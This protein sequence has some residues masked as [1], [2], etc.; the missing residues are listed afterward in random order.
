MPA[1]DWS[2]FSLPDPPQTNDPAMYW[3]YDVM[4]VLHRKVD[5]LVKGGCDEYGG[6]CARVERLETNDEAQDRS[7]SKFERLWAQWGGLAKLM[8][9]LGAVIVALAATLRLLGLV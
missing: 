2:D 4:F 6:L 5:Q 1:H 8:T 9:S 3:L 7:L